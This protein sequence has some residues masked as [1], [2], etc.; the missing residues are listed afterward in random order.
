MTDISMNRPD[1][2]K[3][4]A[5]AK[6]V[7]IRRVAVDMSEALMRAE[8]ILALKKVRDEL[9]EL[10]DS[11]YLYSPNLAVKNVQQINDHLSGAICSIVKAVSWVQPTGVS[12]NET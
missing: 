4:E 12:K 5:E 2:E 11:E 9:R 10:R 6:V 8:Y 3:I 7:P 1:A